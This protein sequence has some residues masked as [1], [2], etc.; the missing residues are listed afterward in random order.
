MLCIYLKLKKSIKKGILLD[1]GVLFHVNLV[2]RQEE[3]HRTELSITEF[4]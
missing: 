1:F 2:A 4:D 3:Q